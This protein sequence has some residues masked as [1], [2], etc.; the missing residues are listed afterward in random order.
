[1]EPSGFQIDSGDALIIVP[2]FAGLDRPSLGA[3]ILQSTAKEAG[4]KVSVLYANMILAAKIGALNYES[5]CY[6]PTGIL[7][8]ERFFASAAYGLPP[9]GSDGFREALKNSQK[10]YLSMNLT[11]CQ[12]IPDVEK[13]QKYA[14][15]W[16]DNIAS[17]VIKCGFKV[18]G[19]T[20][21]FEQT[22]ASIALLNRI[23]HLDPNVITILG[24]ANCQEEMAKGILSLGSNIDYIFSGE[25]E[26]AFSRFLREVEDGKHKSSRIILGEPCMNLDAIPTPEFASFYSQLKSWL[27][28]NSFKYADNIWLPYESSRGCW[29]GQRHQCNFCGINGD[30]IDF[31]QKSAGRVISELK[32]LIKHHPNRQICMVDNNMP[33][34][35]FKSLIPNL[36][37]ELPDARFFYEVRP[38][39]SLRHIVALKKGGI[40]IIQP[41]IESLST[42]CL[43]LMNKGVT[44]SQN[45]SLLRYSRS[46][47]LIV[48]W[49]LLYGFPGDHA[50]EY[51]RMMELIPLLHHLHPPNDLLHLS[52]DRFSPYFK[53]PERYGISNLRPA[54]IYSAVLPNGS[55]ITKMAYHF[56]GDYRSESRENP[57]L[58]EELRRRV[59]AWR[60]AWQSENSLPILAV[61]EIGFDRYMLLDTRGLPDRGE[62]S[63]ITEEQ[64]SL[65]LAGP[66]EKSGSEIKWALKDR[67]IV[68][69]DSNYV[70]L[71]TASPD[72]L[73]KFTAD[74]KSDSYVIA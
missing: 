65:I 58:M 47:G 22:N 37:E 38:N 46:A 6:A 17:E 60:V 4:F 35:F 52:L 14:G 57:E 49:N 50:D 42:P 7:L 56:I 16:V 20:T 23:K 29:W 26:L 5:I 28:E 11:P 71:A 30:V 43:K 21:T 62:I 3:H 32:E 19:C 73:N 59:E 54:D 33:A 40:A 61:T 66:D 2:P 24:G 48:H 39:L 31:R 18:V 9:L 41:G 70:P 53:D 15:E 13:L 44:A 63:F 12:E 74:L 8:G 69:I 64:A 34:G 72:I 67:L 25:C 45:I 36:N 68:E 10:K 51:E 55:D 1:M 27:P